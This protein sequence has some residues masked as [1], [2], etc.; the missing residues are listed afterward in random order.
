M[1]AVLVLA[2]L[3][4]IP[5]GLRSARA[6]TITNS[7]SPSVIC[8][9]VACFPPPPWSPYGPRVNN[10][11][12]K[13]YATDTA[14]YN[15]F[16][17]GG[18][19]VADNNGASLT[20]PPS[21]TWPVYD[22]NPD[23]SLS[24]IQA[25]PIWNGIY[26]NGAAST[27]LKWGCDWQFYNSACGIEVREAFAHLIDRPRFVSDGP[28]QGAGAPL[29]DPSPASMFQANG[30]AY[31][32]S[33]AT[34]CSWE[35][36][37][38]LRNCIGAF[39]LSPDSGGFAQPGS[40]DFCAAVDH[41]IQA[42]VYSP[43]L[44]LRRNPNAPIDQFGNHCGI[45]PSSPGITNIIASPMRFCVRSPEPRRSLGIGFANS[46]D[47]LFGATA[48]SIQFGGFRCQLVFTE[49]PLSP[50]DD[51]DA[52][53]YGYQSF[54][55]VPDF[56]YSTYNSQ[57]AFAVPGCGSSTT[58]QP[59]NP[60]FV[61]I[62]AL[63]TAT[64][65]AAHA[66]SLGPFTQDTLQAFN[67][68]GSHA[69]EIPGYT[70][71]VRTPALRAVDGLVNANAIGY[72]NPWT[73][74]SGH[75]GG[76][77]PF[78]SRY[79]FGGGDQNTLRYGQAQP[80]YF[81]NP[82]QAETNMEL[83]VLS[84]VYDNLFQEN[85]TLPVQAFC[86]M[87]DSYVQSV[88]SSGNTHFLVDLR[89]NLRWQDGVAFDPKDVKFSLL[90]LRD[91]AALFSGSLFMLLNVNILGSTTL[92]IVMQGQ[93]VS[94]IFNLSSVPMIPRHIW[95]L[96]GDATYGDVGTAD[97]AKVDPSYDPIT[98]GTFIGSGPFMCR[99][100]FSEDLGRVGTG[101]SKDS[102]GNRI[103]ELQ[104]PGGSITLQLYDRIGESGNLDPF[105]QYMRSY[106]P[107]WATGSGTAPFSGQFQEFSWADRYDNATVTIA[108]LNSVAN[109]Y[110]K[111]SP[112]GCA[113]YS[114]WLRS[115]FHPGTPNTI[116]T[117]LIIVATHYGDTGVYPFSWSGNQKA[118]P[119]QQIQ[120]IIPFTP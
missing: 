85:P 28:L 105:L 26:F 57:F 119:G 67:V 43:A 77:T 111:S 49:P 101:C 84:E 9:P 48:V 14:E 86:W 103:G 93:S 109:C 113:D 118:Q 115:A 98:S 66:G 2:I 1:V 68:L 100:L 29:A 39:N 87:C 44:G 13:F 63:D 36:I 107:A 82:Y 4:A 18:L 88:D 24:P 92:E 17:N 3:P 70:F 7:P 56:L 76:Y 75:K 94:H 114:Y 95:E 59:T 91:S 50:V 51:W 46:L 54:S 6:E 78:D 52:Y 116:S 38:S 104:E 60:S 34:Q 120:N 31:A 21:S 32:S 61:C 89:Q 20:G 96:P 97:P 62:P 64:S 30:T 79:Q 37:P 99:S 42:S 16:L 81:L 11:E 33:L 65:N 108:D 27:W 22:A 106:N 15:D 19:D 110:G 8:L 12:F 69:V 55:P 83:N 41:L 23:L 117:E 74:L 25:N 80:V 5:L 35:T 73:M 90:T 72:D 112:S 71:A 47:Q 45:D 40:P 102:F 10:L 53:T 58:P